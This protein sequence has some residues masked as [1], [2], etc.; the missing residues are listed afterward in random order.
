[1]KYNYYF[2][3]DSNFRN[4]ERILMLRSKY[5]WKGYGLYWAFIELMFE[6]GIA[7][8]THSKIAGMASGLNIKENF[9]KEF[10]SY[11]IKEK[12]FESDDILFW[13]EDLK[14]KINLMEKVRNQK[15]LAGK[16]GMEKRWEK[17]DD[18]AY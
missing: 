5:G 17:D 3:H 9:A 8:L 6:T 4:E 18:D 14:E 11:C 1:M 10:I 12:L 15:S 7:Y 13:S 2:S 16:K